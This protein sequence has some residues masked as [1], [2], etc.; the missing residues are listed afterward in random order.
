[1][2]GWVLQYVLVFFSLPSGKR[3]RSRR[4]THVYFPIA[5]VS[6]MTDGYG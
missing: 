5:V 1:M 6:D 3:G 4:N 2:K